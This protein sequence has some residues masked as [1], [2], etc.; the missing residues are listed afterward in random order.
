VADA[1]GA[2]VEVPADDVAG[3]G[4]GDEELPQALAARAPMTAT[5]MVV[6]RR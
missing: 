5:T 6:M 3:V 2:V 4:V 1:V